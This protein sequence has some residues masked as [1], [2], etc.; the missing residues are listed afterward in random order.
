MNIPYH[1]TQIYVFHRN[2][3]MKEYLYKSTKFLEQSSEL[4]FTVKMEGNI[5]NEIALEQGTK[6]SHFFRRE[7]WLSK[8]QSNLE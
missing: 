4:N 7:S 8:Y 5:C 3:F 6:G 2:A 1:H